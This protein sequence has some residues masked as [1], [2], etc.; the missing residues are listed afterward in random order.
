MLSFYKIIVIPQSCLPLRFHK[1]KEGSQRK[2]PWCSSVLLSV[3][4][5]ITLSTN[6]ITNLKA[7][8][9]SQKFSNPNYT[10][11]LRWKSSFPDTNTQG[12]A[13]SDH[14]TGS[15][16]FIG[17]STLQSGVVYWAMAAYRTE[18]LLFSEPC[19]IEPSNKKNSPSSK[20]IE[21]SWELGCCFRLCCWP[22][23]L[24]GRLVGLWAFGRIA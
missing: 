14:L 15:F 2:N 9:V 13:N 16:Q 10:R 19:H 24:F 1:E 3:L 5:G 17:I 21:T 11:E 7:P 12:G 22:I 20:S 6:Y 23:I 18:S 8:A 4:C